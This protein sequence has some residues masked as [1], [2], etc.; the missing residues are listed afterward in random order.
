[1][2]LTA[3]G[4]FVPT[5]TILMSRLCVV[6]LA[7]RRVNCSSDGFV[8]ATVENDSRVAGDLRTVTAALIVLSGHLRLF[9]ADPKILARAKEHEILR[10]EAL[11]AIDRLADVLG[12]DHPL[13]VHRG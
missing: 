13:R 9:S 12:V 6:L 10:D 2:R 7:V 8:A 4:S 11:D 5:T 3:C 1:M